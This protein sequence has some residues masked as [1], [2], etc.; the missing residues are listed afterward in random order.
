[1]TEPRATYTTTRADTPDNATLRASA[2]WQT[3]QAKR[4][5]ATLHGYIVRQERL[6]ADPLTDDA[7]LDGIAADMRDLRVRLEALAAG[8]ENRH[9][10]G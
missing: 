2:I 1:M 7:T 4:L 10:C 8:M 5:A 3:A 9:G 6:A